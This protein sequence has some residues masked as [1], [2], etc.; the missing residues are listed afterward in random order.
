MTKKQLIENVSEKTHS[1]FESAEQLVNATFDAIKA[2]LAKGEKVEIKNFGVF[3]V[4]DVAE[5]NGH[6]PRTGEDIVIPAHKFPF[7]RAGKVLKN[8]VNGNE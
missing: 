1:K 5:R 3:G 4:K 6:N 2:T 8:A 7:F